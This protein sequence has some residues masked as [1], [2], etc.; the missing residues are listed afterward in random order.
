MN[1]PWFEYGGKR[2]YKRM[3]LVLKEGKVE[4]VFYPVLPPD[5]NAGDVLAW[6]KANAVQSQ[7]PL[8]YE[9]N[10]WRTVRR[11]RIPFSVVVV[12]SAATMTTI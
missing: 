8:K 6:L 1:L 11:W 9:P 10:Q 7:K 2:L 3:A 12:V 4:Q 5:R